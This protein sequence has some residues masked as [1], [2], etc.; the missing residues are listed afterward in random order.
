VSGRGAA[1]GVRHLLRVD[2]SPRG[3]VDLEAWP[4]TVPAVAQLVREGGMDVAP[5]VTLL[6][7]ENGSGK[8]TLV[9]ALA[10]VYPRSGAR[11][12]YAHLT[13]PDASEEDSP[14]RRHLVARTVPLA[15]RAGFFLRAEVMHEFLATVDAN[16][17]ESKAW[18]GAELRA[19]SHGE[20]FLTV[21]RHRFDEVGVYFLDEPEAP[22]S[23]Q[24]TLSLLLLLDMLRREGSQVV[25]ATHSPMLAALP[26]ATL[27]EVGEWGMRRVGYDELELARSWRDFMASPDRYLHYLLAD[28]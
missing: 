20:A 17:A 3:E 14:L 21:L 19:R 12:N 28:A 25:V 2:W 4:F 16:P 22:L 27:I 1:T 9:E 26:G 5:G 11:S 15:A 23:F 24:S 8:S 10:A 18:G 7:G 13:G 6:A